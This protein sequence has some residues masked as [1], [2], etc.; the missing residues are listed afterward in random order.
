MVE[1]KL[2]SDFKR[3]KGV[4]F[5]IEQD[6]GKLGKFSAHPYERGFATT[7]GNS[8]RRTLLSSVP[9]YAIIAAKFDCINNEYQNIPGV[10]QDTAE[11][12]VNL[13]NVAIKILDE[14]VTSKVFHYEINGKCDFTAA[15]LVKDSTVM[16]G[17]PDHLIMKCNKDANF[18]M[19]VE[20][21]WGRGYVP[22][23]EYQNAIETEGVILIDANYSPI[24]RVSYEVE[25]IRLANRSDYEK[26]SM[27]IETNGVISPENALKE[28]AQILKESY[29][30]FNNIELEAMLTSAVDDRKE[31]GEIEKDKI[32]LESVFCLGMTVRTYYFLKINDI[33]EVGQLVTKTEEEIRSKEGF[34]EKI[35]DDIKV[36]LDL[37]NLTL[38]MKDINYS[39]KKMI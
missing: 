31:G 30:T 28:A 20:V 1:Q 17:N 12:L 35:L 10:Y 8:L 7:I 19:D 26:L 27:E 9:G 5:L 36:R 22:A 13:R 34:C 29:M 2:V 6:N 21:R 16:V 14:N 25:K 33:R 15:D 4:E 24:N 23:D 39:P 32:F 18:T 37:K 11:I 3:P 38:G